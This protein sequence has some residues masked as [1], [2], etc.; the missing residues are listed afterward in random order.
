[1]LARL[2]NLLDTH[3]TFTQVVL[4]LA[5]ALSAYFTTQLKIDDSPERWMPASTQEAWRKFERHFEA[6]D[7]IGIGLHFQR[8]VTDQ[9][10]VLLHD[11]RAALEDVDGIRQVYD[12][13]LISEEI[14]RVPLTELLDPEEAE[15][16]DLYTGAFWDKPSGDGTRTLLTVCELVFHPDEARTSPDVLNDRRRHVI[17]EVDRVVK[18]FRERAAGDGIVFHVAGGILMMGEMEARCRQVAYTFLPAS[19]LVG[20]LSLLFGFRSGRAL[21]VAV[22]GGCIS[23]LLV[24]GWLG[25]GG[26]SL[27]VVTMAAPTLIAIISIASTIHFAAWSSEH[28]TTGE[29]GHRWATIDWVAVPCFGAALTTGVGFLMLSF[30]ELIPIRDLGQQMFAG[31]ILAFFGVFCVTQIVPI[32]RAYAGSWLTPARLRQIALKCTR[33]PKATVA[34]ASVLVVVLAFFAWPR[35]KYEPIGLYIDAD[36]FS[37]FSDDQPIK[38]ALRHFSDRKFAVYTL[39]IVMVPNEQGD[40]GQ[41]LNPPDEVFEAN[42][43]A[44]VKLTQAIENRKDLGVIRVLSTQAF[45]DR[46]EEFQRELLRIRQEE[47]WLA[48]AAKLA[49]YSNSANMLNESFRA[50]NMDKQSEQARRITVVAHDTDVGFAPLVEEVESLL[51]RDRYQCYLAGSVAQNVDLAQG[52]GDGMLYGLGT[53]LIVMGIL[54]GFLFRSW[55]LAMMAFVP[56]I[57]PILMV[58]GFMGLFKLPISSGSAMVATIALGIA[59]NDTIHF[60]LH[61]RQRTRQEGMSVSAATIE[62]VQSLGRPIV[63]TSVVHIAGFLIFLLTDFLP[64]YHFGQL[65]AIAML[66][67]LVGDL[68][69]LPNLLLV[70]DRVPPH[71]LASP[72]AA[73]TRHAAPRP[74]EEVIGP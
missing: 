3:R 51:P 16:F 50:W 61:Y 40:E 34:M 66:A 41:G 45:R 60:L 38:L 67:A 6:G 11:L 24:L 13:S 25:A 37:F 39:E 74:S 2:L 1:M 64:L 32:R 58:F 17:A 9:D 62:T 12:C 15:R 31:S 4:W 56:N 71:H 53:S 5:V 21:I 27:G 19:V 72:P 52:M 8:P 22:G 7:N 73:A 26:G 55:R 48:F 33:W 28:G 35:P 63:M 42:R 57:F 23:M 68:V 65:S 14:E 47:G 20:L 70:F 43:L 46:Y 69:I 44:A 59:L 49:H 29:A 18:E 36:P 10:V 30:N 54:C